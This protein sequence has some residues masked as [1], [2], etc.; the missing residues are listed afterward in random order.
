MNTL[1]YSRYRKSIQSRTVFEG[2]EATYGL[3]LEFDGWVDRCDPLGLGLFELPN[4]R[5]SVLV[6]LFRIFIDNL[7]TVLPE[8]PHDVASGDVVGDALRC[9]VALTVGNDD[10]V[11]AVVPEFD[12]A[13]PRSWQLLSGDILKLV[14]K[15]C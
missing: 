6:T 7:L 1:C 2:R 4:V 9:I 12:P 8:L 5:C 11:V 10:I 15:R 14:D 3:S 13:G